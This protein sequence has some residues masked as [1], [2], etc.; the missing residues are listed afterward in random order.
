MVNRFSTIAG[1]SK[2]DHSSS[3][4]DISRAADILW[5]AYGEKALERA[6][7]LEARTPTSSFAKKVRAEM[8]RQ[9]VR[10][11]ATGRFYREPH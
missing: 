10:T 1:E 11:T 7:L 4:A 9:P 2:I 5:T 8:E 3:Y 6:K